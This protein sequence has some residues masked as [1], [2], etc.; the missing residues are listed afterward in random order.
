MVAR[1]RQHRRALAQLFQEA[2]RRLELA[3]T[4][5]LRQVTRHHNGPGAERRYD[6][7]DGVDHRQVAI[8]PEVQVGQVHQGNWDHHTVR[9]V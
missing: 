9:I 7:L 3:V 1:Q 6:P 2:S 5:A 8:A 4:S